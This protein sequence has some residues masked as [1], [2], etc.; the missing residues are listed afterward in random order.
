MPRV[1]L[2]RYWFL[3]YSRPSR[4]MG[5]F[6]R[7]GGKVALSLSEFESLLIPVGPCPIKPFVFQQKQSFRAP[8]MFGLFQA[9][10]KGK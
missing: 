8:S 6:A 3:L 1:V 9:R 4:Q 7:E 10:R 2:R 5:G